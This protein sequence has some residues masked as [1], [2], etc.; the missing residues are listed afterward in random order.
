MTTPVVLAIVVVLYIFTCI[1]SWRKLS[2][3]GD[4]L[5]RGKRNTAPPESTGASLPQTR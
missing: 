4:S 3:Q 1:R 5:L 2:E